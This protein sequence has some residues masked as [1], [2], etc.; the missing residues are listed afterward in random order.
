M[1]VS[2]TLSRREGVWFPTSTS[3][4]DPVLQLWCVV[5]AW[6]VLASQGLWVQDG[7]SG[8]YLLT[9]ITRMHWGQL[10]F[11]C[12]SPEEQTGQ[13]QISCCAVAFSLRMSAS[14]ILHDAEWGWCLQAAWPVSASET[15]WRW[16]WSHSVTP[17]SGKGQARGESRPPGNSFPEVASSG[18]KS[19]SLW[20]RASHWWKKKLISPSCG[21]CSTGNV[22]P[23]DR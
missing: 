1:G 20:N 6:G 15:S 16:G 22:V 18:T 11:C 23:W 19:Q 13:L 4:W 21:A 12:P 17:C 3:W 2:A 7:T 8:M 5:C 14:N 10:L 9:C